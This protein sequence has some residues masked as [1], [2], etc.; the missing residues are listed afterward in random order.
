MNNEL[1]QTKNLANLI[2]VLNDIIPEGYL[3]KEWK[4]KQG[5]KL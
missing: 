5:G 4:F 2:Q 1:Y 3:N